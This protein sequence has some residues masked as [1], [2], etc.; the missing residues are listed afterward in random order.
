MT[1]VIKVDDCCMLD[2]P[3]LPVPAFAL[4]G[5]LMFT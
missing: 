4:G 1:V 2:G 5:G 3:L